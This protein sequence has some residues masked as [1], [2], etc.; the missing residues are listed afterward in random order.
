MDAATQI[1]AAVYPRG[2]LRMIRVYPSMLPGEPIETHRPSDGALADWL[3]DNVPDF[4]IGAEQH[5]IVVKQG[6]R[7]I[8]PNEWVELAVAEQPIDIYIAPQ[9][10]AVDAISGAISSV[11][12]A[13]GSVVNAAVSLVGDI[14]GFLLPSAPGVNQA[15]G[16]NQG[17]SIYDPNV[18]ANRPKLGGV[19]PEIAGQHKVFPDY[20]NQPRRYF[21]DQR[22]LAVDVFTCIGKGSYLVPQS[23]IRIGATP[24]S[25]LGQQVDLSIFEPGADVTSHPS[26]R[27]WYNAP[28]VGASVG[29]GAGLRLKSPT[30]VAVVWDVSSVDVNGVNVTRVSGDAVPDDWTVGLEINVRI[31][32]QIVANPPPDPMTDDH[33]VFSGAFGDLGLSIGDE[34][35]IYGGALDGTYT[36]AS[37]SATE[38]TLDYPD[39]TPVTSPTS[40]TYINTIDLAGARYRIDAFIDDGGM[41]AVNIGFTATKLLSNGSEDAGWLGFPSQRSNSPFIRVS[42]EEV[43]GEWAGPFLGC[44]SG[45]AVSGVEWDVFAPQGLGRVKDDGAIENV[46]RDVELQWR[47]VGDTVWNTDK[48]NVQGKTRD[49]LGWTFFTNFGTTVTP[50]VR[51]RRTSVEGTSIQDLDR[52]EWFGLKSQLS[53]KSSYPGVTTMALTVE[54]SDTIAGQSENKVSAVVTR[55]VPTLGTEIDEPSRNIADWFRY[56]ARNIGYTD[57]DLDQ[58]ELARLAAIWESRGDTFDFVHDGDST[59]LAVM[60]RTLRAGASELT[61]NQG[62]LTPVRDEARSTFEQMYTTQNMVEPLSRSIESIRPDEV[63]G[64]DVEFFSAETWTNETVE[65]RLP[66]DAGNRP[67]KIRIEGVTSRTRAWRSGMRERLRLRYRRKTY[68]FST[69]LDAL[70]SSYWSYCA[71]ADDVPGYTSSGIIEAVEIEGG[72][73]HVSTSEPLDWQDGETHLIAWR[74]PDGTLSGP[75]TATRGD[76]DQ[77][78][79]Y[80]GAAPTVDYSQELPHYMFGVSQTFSYPALISSIEPQGFDA[81]SV[82]A[83]NYDE[84]VY[85]YDNSEPPA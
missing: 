55:L 53:A 36:I 48:R 69:E 1:R 5:P 70:N 12:S 14:F 23:Q 10:G 16:Q 33:A 27:C 49:Q 39:L 43:N 65:C 35:I 17:S 11:I 72:V 83:V 63:D 41:P 78:V 61:I 26:H 73:V 80:T 47:A 21:V 85:D 32:R 18:Q 20:L 64:I 42:D 2:V 3:A 25:A 50:E 8:P 66:G 45:E 82:Q 37:V 51:L 52:L 56:V 34:V 79:I 81:V 71:L 58:E 67:E 7:I 77:H 24:L 76:D 19:I 84:R 30:D 38:I 6:G 4:D 57:D 31:P 54:G 68:S 59:A 13:V 40:G 9:S 60:Q 44:P 28:E 15:R 22:N 74:E 29:S 62:L 46:S 75:Y